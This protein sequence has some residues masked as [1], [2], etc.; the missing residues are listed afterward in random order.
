LLLLAVVPM[1]IRGPLVFSFVERYGYYILAFVGSIVLSRLLTPHQF[2]TYS[3][4]ASIAMVIEVVRDS[5]LGGYIV[6]CK[7]MSVGVLRTTFSLSM[8]ISLSCALALVGAA[9]SASLL[10]REPDIADVL[11]W[12]ALS[13]V[14]LPFGTPSNS[15]LRRDLAFDKVAAIGIAG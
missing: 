9:E 1:N 5:G 11:R 12:L 4:A 6:Q 3:V 14:L 13:F 15:L 7:D 2:G 10:F 8:A